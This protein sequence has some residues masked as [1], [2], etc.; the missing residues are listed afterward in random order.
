MTI[1][2][3]LL[4]LNEESNLGRCLQALSWSDDIVVLDSF[5]GDGTV[6]LARSLGARVYSR[7]FDGFA[8]QRNYALD[9]I[10]FKHEWILHLDA[11]EVVTEGLRDEMFRAIDT[12]LFDAYRVPSKMMFCGRWLRYSG[13]YPTYQV[14]LGRKGRLRFRQFG[15]GQREDIADDHVGTLSEPYLHYSFSKGLAEWFEKHNR[16]SSDEAQ[17]LVGLLSAGRGADLAGIFSSD[18]TR[19]RRALKE[20]SARFPFR[21]TLRFLYMYIFRFGFLDGR[22]GLAYCRLM[23]LY[24]YMIV[25]KARELRQRPERAR[26]RRQ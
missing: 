3:L 20:V 18:P 19:R 13:M 12:G 4:T 10:D 9:H 22:A 5:S 11:D 14:R 1:S 17:E 16:Y 8:G 25:L 7:A 24:E 2:V 21:P 6:D 23:A 26:G 15:H